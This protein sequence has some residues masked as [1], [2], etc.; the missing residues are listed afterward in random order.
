[1]LMHIHLY[2][3]RTW[4]TVNI[5]WELPPLGQM[6]CSCVPLSVSNVETFIQST[7]INVISGSYMVYYVFIR[8]W[9]FITIHAFNFI[10]GLL[11]IHYNCV[12]GNFF[13]AVELSSFTPWKDKR[14][15][16]PKI[17]PIRVLPWNWRSLFKF[18]T[19]H[20]LSFYQELNGHRFTHFN[21]SQSMPSHISWHH[22]KWRKYVKKTDFIQEGML[23][24]TYFKG[25]RRTLPITLL[26]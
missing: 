17:P 14:K 1:M 18:F 6:A 21:A 19:C 12:P 8:S 3:Y 24:T 4:S 2:N 25:L 11:I 16:N 7:G 22:V 26:L 23:F 9:I 10:L 15:E 5:C 13:A 20:F